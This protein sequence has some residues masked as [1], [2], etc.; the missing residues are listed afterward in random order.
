MGNVRPIYSAEC[1]AGGKGCPDFVKNFRFGGGK[2]IFTNESPYDSDTTDSNAID[3]IS[4]AIEQ[5]RALSVNEDGK[6]VVPF[7]GFDVRH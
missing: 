4:G 2:G 7:V 6:V 1:Y 5:S 3:I